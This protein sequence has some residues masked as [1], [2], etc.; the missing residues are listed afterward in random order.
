MIHKEQQHD[1]ENITTG[2]NNLQNKMLQV[3]ST[4]IQP[5][6]TVHQYVNHEN[7]TRQEIQQQ[8][9]YKWT[10]KRKQRNTIPQNI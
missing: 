8:K 3:A 10:I 4:L 9:E 6:M 5:Q 7:M 2:A 1:K